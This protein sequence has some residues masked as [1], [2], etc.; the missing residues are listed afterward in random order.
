MKVTTVL[1]LPSYL[2]ACNPPEMYSFLWSGR[3]WWISPLLPPPDYTSDI[4]KRFL[5]Y[6]VDMYI[7]SLQG[8][9]NF[10]INFMNRVGSNIF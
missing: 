7:V 2:G 6:L 3:G 9:L 5:I 4:K 1:S 10:F 8:L